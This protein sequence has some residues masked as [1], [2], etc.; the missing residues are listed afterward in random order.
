MISA[1]YS[2]DIKLSPDNQTYNDQLLGDFKK[3][4]NN[5]S[6]GFFNLTQNNSLITATKKVYENFKHK[7]HFIHVGIGGS[8]LGAEMLITALGKKTSTQFIF[9]NNIDADEIFD[10]LQGIDAK[11]CLF[12]IVS[13]SGTTAETMAAMAIL[14]TWAQIKLEDF[15][16]YFVF[17]TDPEVGDL[18]K[19]AQDYQI[20]ALDIPAN[21][22]GRF[23]ALTPVGVFPAL[24]AGIQIEQLYQGAEAI[25]TSLLENNF[26]KNILLQTATALFTLR[27]KNITQTV[28]MPYSSKL[29]NLS[30]WFVQLW[31]ESLG[32]KLNHQGKVVNT[33]FTP[34][35]AYGATDQHSQVQLFMEGPFDKCLILIEVQKRQHD[36]S[37][38]NN[39]PCDSLN[40]L[41]KFS[42]NQLM[43]A[44][45]K[46]TVK[47][48]DE[49]KRP[50]IHLSIEKLNESN[51][52]GLILFLESLTALV[53]H[54]L[55]IDPFNQPGVEAGK[56]FAWQWLDKA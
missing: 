42:L 17:S 50:Y 36:F 31:A 29:K 52:G 43:E 38:K 23:S 24:F 13:K 33:G 21:I 41:Q 20:S 10:Q 6:F 54:M 12:H 11:D 9:I 56:K 18:R 51:L 8:H 3:I 49:A 45:F 4:I 47:A 1:N 34:I 35:P 14:V 15:K 39:L 26:Q 44:E 27:Q 40:K 5:Q 28:F 48:L 55:E 16:N 37:L 19:M 7:K 25:K 22:G 46:G 32:K 30:F 2:S 53:G